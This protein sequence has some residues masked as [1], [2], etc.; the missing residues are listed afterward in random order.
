MSKEIRNT[1]A[2]LRTG[3]HQP[4]DTLQRFLCV[5]PVDVFL[6][7]IKDLLD[8]DPDV[9][10]T[11]ICGFASLKILGLFSIHFLV[12]STKDFGNLSILNGKTE[13]IALESP[14]SY[15]VGPSDDFSFAHSIT[16][17]VIERNSHACISSDVRRSR[18]RDGVDQFLPL[19]LHVMK[20]IF[21]RQAVR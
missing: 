10:G 7:A 5:A 18:W 12:I 14:D 11:D 6:H 19:D 21:V 13:E 3:K 20:G 2:C 1:I 8:I 17:N 4:L 16:S 9:A 15:P